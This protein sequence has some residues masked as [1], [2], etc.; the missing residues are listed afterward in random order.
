MGRK[1]DDTRVLPGEPG[2]KQDVDSGVEA[3]G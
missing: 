1:R 2:T 3:L